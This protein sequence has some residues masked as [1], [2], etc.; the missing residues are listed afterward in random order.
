MRHELFAPVADAI[1]KAAETITGPAQDEPFLLDI[2]PKTDGKTATRA[3]SETE[4]FLT[5]H[6]TALLPHSKVLG[7]ETT[8][9]W[10][11]SPLLKDAGTIWIIDP[12]DGTTPY[13]QGGHYGIIVA[14][15][16][17]GIIDAAWIYFPM[18]RDMLFASQDDETHCI[19]WDGK[20]QP[21]CKK[22]TIP[23]SEPSA[24]NLY[25]CCPKQQDYLGDYQSVADLFKSRARSQCIATET[26]DMLHNGTSATLFVE[27]F[28]PWDHKP[29]GYIVNRA[30]GSARFF[31]DTAGNLTGGIL[32]PNRPIFDAMLSQVHAINPEIIAR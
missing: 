11:S 17:K 23:Q 6:L 32:A 30:G 14:L 2:R 12:I 19:K 28:T 16:T 4:A 5:R 31:T 27:Q 18:T 26:H 9:D 3:D 10:R 24:L 8:D 7:E 20:N 1:R 22:I 15:Q 13:S 21:I 25:Y 29:A